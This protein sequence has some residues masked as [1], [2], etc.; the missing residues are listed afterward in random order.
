MIHANHSN[1]ENRSYKSIRRI[2]TILQEV[3]SNSGAHFTLGRHS[4]MC[5]LD[6]ILAARVTGRYSANQEGAQDQRNAKQGSRLEEHSNGST[7]VPL[8]LAIA[9]LV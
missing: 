6:L 9:Q 7:I 8:M 4:A 2:S 1:A 5:V 3:N